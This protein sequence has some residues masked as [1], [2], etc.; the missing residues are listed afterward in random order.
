[1]SMSRY[2]KG[3]VILREGDLSTSVYEVMQGSVAT[4]AS[5]GQPHQKKLDSLKAGDIFGEQAMLNGCPLGATAV[6]E[7]EGTCVR[8]IATD[9]MHDF[10]QKEPA[11]V[12][13]MMQFL[14]THL[15]RVTLEYEAASRQI[16]ERTGLSKKEENAGAYIYRRGQIIF[17]EGEAGDC[18]YFLADGRVGIFT[19]Y[20][21]DEQRL[22]VE[23]PEESFFGEMGM[24]E[25]L[26]RSATAVAMVDETRLERIDETN[27]DEMIKNSPGMTFAALQ[28]LSSRLQA[29]TEDNAKAHKAL[30]GMQRA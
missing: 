17:R 11:T 19:G 24:L 2:K 21:T 20:G 5:Y 29:M 27:L 4:Y 8:E 16:A 15:R 1:M 9:T 3:E 23:L 30:E 26:P 13:K 6:A 18:M 7:E 28:H 14:G 12:R 25:K 22:I 10:I